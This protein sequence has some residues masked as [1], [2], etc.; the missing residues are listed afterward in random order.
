[1]VEPEVCF[2]SYEELIDLAIN[3]IK[4]CID[5]VIENY[6]QDIEFIDKRVSKDKFKNLVSYR[7]KPFKKLSYTEA[8]D[9]LND[10]SENPDKLSWGD[11]LSTTQ[12]K[13][14]T[15]IYGPTVVYDYPKEIKSFYMKQN[16]D[17]KTVQA[18]DILVPEIGELIGGSMREENYE[19]LN[20]VM[21]QHNLEG[22]SLQW[23]LDL[24]KNGTVPHGGFGMGFERLVMLIMGVPNIKDC[25]HFPRYPNYCIN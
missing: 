3:Y 20:D 4:Y 9:I 8:V 11:D 13:L 18:M 1:M 25:V 12:E 10:N 23:Y 17:G 22:D 15:K 6:R 14:L 5:F 19:K 21:K 2:V 7:D 24:R 16:P